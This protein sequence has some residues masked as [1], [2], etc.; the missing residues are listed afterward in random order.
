MTLTVCFG[1]DANG[2]WPQYT[3]GQHHDSI[4][5]GGRAYNRPGTSLEIPLIL[6][7]ET[8]ET[9]FDA[10][11]ATSV[12]SA[13][14]VEISYNFKSPFGRKMEFR[15][16]VADWDTDT[17]VEG[18]NLESP[19][20]PGVTPDAVNYNYESK[21][22]SFEL[23][24][25]RPLMQGVTLFAGPR[26]VHFE[27]QVNLTT[28]LTLDPGFGSPSLPAVDRQSFE[29]INNII[30]LQAGLN[31]DYQLTQWFKLKGF[32]RTGG[33][34]NPT[35][36]YFNNTQS[37]A[38]DTAELASF[39]LNKSTGTFLAETG[40][41]IYVDLRPGAV[42]LYGGYE[43]TWID[44]VALAPTQYLTVDVDGNRTDTVQTANTLFM[45]A[46]TFGLRMSY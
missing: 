11:Q 27:D 16:I 19:L 10:N 33:Y 2:Q 34:V 45:H 5:I 43:A 8:G 6:E 30:G 38:G 1:N 24:A 41:R 22:F 14:G 9:L 29:A 18:A 7:S 13:P 39:Q 36:V 23:N 3:E 15:T 42:Q 35:K 17:F 31:V 32:I 12:S 44:G 37:A 4:E 28:N 26:F 46:I 20:F 25:S 21:L 40:G